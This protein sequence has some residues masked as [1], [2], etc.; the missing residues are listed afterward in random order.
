M[1]KLL[2]WLLPLLMLAMPAMAD[3]LDMPVEEG[4]T[5]VDLNGSFTKLT[6]KQ[7]TKLIGDLAGYPEIT[8]VEMAEVSVT[9]NQMKRLMKEHPQVDFHWTATINGAKIDSD[10]TVVNFDELVLS[11]TKLSAMRTVL[12]V[13]PKVEEV[14][15]YKFTFSFG[16][17]ENLLESYPHIHFNWK[18]HWWICDGRMVDMRTDATAFSTMKGRQEPR[19]TAAQIMEK[20]K[21]TPNLLAFDAG[22]NNVNDLSFLRNWPGLRW[23]IVVDSK[24]PI[25]DISVLAELP[26]LEYVELFMQDITDISALAN[27]TKLLDLNLCDNNITDLSPLYSCVNLER[28]HIADNPNLTQEE[29]DKL[30]EALP[31]CV[32]N[33]TTEDYTGDGWR[34]HPRYEILRKGFQEYTYYPF[35]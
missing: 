31:N 17:M 27:H 28:L 33:A 20:L 1:R 25:T 32:I 7:I 10:A 13:L 8:R 12:D 3:V 22:H 23:L 15:M 19:L 4:A 9:T 34:E 14:F 6:D 26:D 30:Q 2:L 18:I 16:T 21:Y 35:D 29:L 11:S 5:V 24:K